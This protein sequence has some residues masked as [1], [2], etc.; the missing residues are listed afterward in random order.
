M[1]AISSQRADSIIQEQVSLLGTERIPF[2]EAYGRALR[3]PV[4]ADRAFPPFDRVMMDGIAIRGKDFSRGDRTF[5]SEGIQRAGAEAATLMESGS[6]IEVVTGAVLPGGTDTVIPVEK[7]AA[8]GTVFQLNEGYEPLPGQFI[9]RRGSDNL[10]GDTLLEAGVILGGKEM[11]LVATCGYKEV[12]VSVIPRVTI[13]S[14]GDELVEVD[15]T[16]APFQIRK[17]NAYALAAACEAQ[18]YPIRTRLRHLPD[19]REKISSKLDSILNDS[20]MVLFSGGISKGKYD[21]LEELLGAAGVKQ[22]FHWVRQRPGKPL[23]F[24][25]T[26]WGIPVFA[27]PGNPNSTL[28]CFY[29]YVTLFTDKMIG[30]GKK[31]SP[32]ALLKAPFSFDKLLTLFLPA[33]IEF[34]AGGQLLAEPVAPQNSGDLARLAH[35]DGFVEL[36]EDQSEFPVGFP[37]RFYSW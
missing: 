32:T 30:L 7:V 9:H 11:A 8:S 5:H 27:L 21:F 35:T 15:Q 26:E 3:E 19:D 28:T 2:Q 13:V 25:T 24:G 17:S 34:A 10:R 1:D 22:H 16:P 12:T 18:A 37:V 33:N 31:S 20:D 6:C 36:P 14:T 29:R 23:W 4:L